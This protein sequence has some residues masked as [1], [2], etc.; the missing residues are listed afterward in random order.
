MRCV[1]CYIV[2]E[3]KLFL[4]QPIQASGKLL[5]MMESSA[6]EFSQSR[7]IIALKDNSTG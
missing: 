5:A 6:S 2:K 1:A 7:S 4:S 3:E